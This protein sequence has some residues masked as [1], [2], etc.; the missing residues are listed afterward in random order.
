M[1]SHDPRRRR[2]ARD[3]ARAGVALSAVM[4]VVSLA[5][6]LGLGRDDA[7]AATDAGALQVNSPPGTPSAGQPLSSGTA[8]TGFALAPPSGA[9]CTGDSA[10]DDY[11]IHSFM[12][13][14]SVDPG[15]IT[16]DAD[17]PT[18]QSLGS[19]LRAPLFST[20]GTPF[21]N[22]LTAV[23]TPTSPGG[24][25][26]GLPVISF[27]A[28]VGLDVPP[29]AYKVGFACV[30][31]SPGAAVVLDRWWTAQL[32]LDATLGWT[33]AAPP[34]GSTT[35]TVSPG[36]TAAGTTTTV[37][38]GATTTTV[39]S[40]ASTTTSVAGGSTTT[41][42]GGSTTTLRLSSGGVG[43]SG[44]TTSSGGSTL[45]VTGSSPWA[46]LMW[47]TLFV[48]CGRMAILLGRPIRVIPHEA[49]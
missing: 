19:A 47:A 45:V 49:R 13:P 21:V 33:A 44:G 6:S 4:F 37:R 36:S 30:Q 14:A 22:A 7:F 9:A 39:R 35:T 11:R 29:G 3:V 34:S 8:T 27:G 23:K 32:T 15:T 12:V 26:T 46:M 17:G 1:T 20:A 28:L 41:I 18:P 31:A 16:Y 10:S 25:L 48:I 43:S 38:S 5:G 42:A 24:L 40:G 2:L